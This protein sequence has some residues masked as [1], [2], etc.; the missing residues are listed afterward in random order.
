MVLGIPTILLI[1]RTVLPSNGLL[2]L[3]GE[4]T[5]RL[6]KMKLL[7]WL[8]HRHNVSGS[9][10]AGKRGR[11]NTPEARSPFVNPMPLSRELFREN[12]AQYG[13]PISGHG[14]SE[15]GR[16]FCC[17]PF[18]TPRDSPTAVFKGAPEATLKGLLS[19]VEMLHYK[20]YQR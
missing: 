4:Y 11:R 17:Q 14:Y 12:V 10:I 15:S 16:A 2:I 5:D 1:L 20:Y 7:I 6:W 9:F 8:R 13:S 19:L 18:A 3:V